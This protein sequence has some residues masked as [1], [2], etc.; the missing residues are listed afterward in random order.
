MKTLHL[1]IFAIAVITL[2]ITNY[3]YEEL[4]PKT[5]SQLYDEYKGKT[6]LTGEVISL[7]DKPSENFTSYD[8][9][10][11]QFLTRPEKYTLVTAS[12]PSET[13]EKDIVYPHF[14]VGDKVQLYLDRGSAGYALSP[15][16]FKMDKRCSSFGPSYLDFEPTHGGVA[17]QPIQFLDLNGNII[18]IPTLNQKIHLSY[19]ANNYSPLN[20]TTIDMNITLNDN[21]NPIFHDTQQLDLKPR[22]GKTITWNFVPTQMGNY[23]IKLRQNWGIYDNK[24]ILGNYT[25]TNYGFSPTQ[26]TKTE[27][28]SPL[29]QFKENHDAYSVS[30]GQS[31]SLV[32]SKTNIPACVKDSTARKLWDRGWVNKS[33]EIYSKY[34]SS[35]IMKKFQSKII[36]NQKAIKIV[37]DYIKENNLKLNVD[38]TSTGFKIVTSLNYEIPSSNYNNLLDVDPKTGIPTRIMSPW[39][40]FY[41]NP[42]WWAELEKYYLGMESNR[43]ENGS[44]VWHVDYRECLECIAPYPIFMV[45]AI[46]G[47]VVLTPNGIPPEIPIEE[48]NKTSSGLELSL[49]IDN[50]YANPAQPIGVDMSLNNTSSNQLTLNKEDKWAR[51][52]LSSGSCSNL[53]FGMAILK[54]YYTE[55]NM[56]GASSLVIYQNIPCPLQPLVKSYTFEPLSTKATQNC[57][58]LFSC[59]GLVGMKTHLEISGFVDNNGLH[60]PFN[61]GTYTIAAGDEWG[62]VTIQHF[63]EAYATPLVG[64]KGG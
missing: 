19:E 42:Q 18:G 38:T 3:S 6:I 48:E 60:R 15:Y 35:D 46:T 12:A 49:S 14:K 22:T 61:V 21:P 47:K 28:L 33:T 25:I 64:V 29:K 9:K 41:K 62:D 45:D 8:I 31:L 7:T 39:T 51:N 26:I 59:T 56:T 24:I 20:R 44:L 1:S 27:S 53:P 57:D 16:S 52:D 36:G 5:L 17:S 34:A 32:V 37:Q 4:T 50:Q 54:G 63:T 13:N 23:T 40:I 11:D 30:C 43:I 58:S 10:T 55:K 2:S